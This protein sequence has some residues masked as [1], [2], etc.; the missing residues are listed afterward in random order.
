MSIKRVPL[1]R[2]TAF[3]A[4]RQLKETFSNIILVLSPVGL[5]RLRSQ[6]KELGV[7]GNVPLLT[8]R[9]F[10]NFGLIFQL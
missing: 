8:D 3:I 2:R 9:K 5:F 6:K 10:V 4:V 7:L 1:M